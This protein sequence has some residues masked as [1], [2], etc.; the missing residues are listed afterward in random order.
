MSTAFWIVMIVIL[1]L[2]V[3]ILTAG[4]N[5]DKT[6]GSDADG[7]RTEEDC[8][9]LEP[10]TAARRAIF[11]YFSLRDVSFVFRQGALRGDQ[12]YERFQFFSSR[13]NSMLYSLDIPRLQPVAIDP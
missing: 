10:R 8:R 6:R 13:V 5:D 3:P 4:Y 7:R 12:I 1:L 11:F 2:I 9:S